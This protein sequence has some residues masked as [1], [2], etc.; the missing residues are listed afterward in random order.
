MALVHSGDGDPPAGSASALKA[1]IEFRRDLYKSQVDR[2]TALDNQSAVLVAASVTL[3][4]LVARTGQTNRLL[5]LMTLLFTAFTVYLALLARQETPTWPPRLVLYGMDR[6]VQGRL[7]GTSLGTTLRRLHRN[8]ELDQDEL[9][10]LIQ[11]SADV[12][13]RVDQPAESAELAYRRIFETWHAWAQSSSARR[14]IK[15]LIHAAAVQSLLGELIFAAI[16]LLTA[17]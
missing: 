2:I 9:Q 15:L 1:Q 3:A 11:T 17:G 5:V 4:G 13:V 8:Y 10:K 7:S 16:A 14:D 6:L 12:G